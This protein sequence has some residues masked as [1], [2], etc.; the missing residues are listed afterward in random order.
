MDR[1]SPLRVPLAVAALAVLTLV[2]AARV[3]LGLSEVVGTG[4]SRAVAAARLAPNGS[5]AALTVLVG[6]LVASCFLGPEVG[7][8]RRLAVWGAA[9]TVLSVVATLVALGLTDAA[10]AGWNLV[11]GLPDLA[12]PALVGAGLLVLARPQPVPTSTAALGTAD[13]AAEADDGPVETA[14]DP[15]LQP[16]WTHDAAAGAVW[17]T[18]GEAARGAPAQEWGTA[19][20]LSW[21]TDPSTPSA[22]PDGTRALPPGR[23]ERDGSPNAS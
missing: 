4:G 18:A 7:V 20:D 16:S 12:V 10:V 22:A 2:A 19:G 1:L 9:L 6:V 14:P 23:D 17:R 11:W 21:P 15:E 8:R 13:A 5:D 3:V